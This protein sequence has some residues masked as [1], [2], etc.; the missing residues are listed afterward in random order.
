MPPCFSLDPW[1]SGV[2]QNKS[3]EKKWAWLTEAALICLWKTADKLSLATNSGVSNPWLWSH[4]QTFHLYIVAPFG[5]G[6]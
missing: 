5:F 2:Q 4:V 3:K 6:K 1:A